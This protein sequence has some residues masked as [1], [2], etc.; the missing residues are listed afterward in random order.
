M[1]SVNETLKGRVDLELHGG[2]SA[3][4][5]GARIGQR[6]LAPTTAISHNRATGRPVTRSLIACSH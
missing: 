1:E 4:G 2:R 6:L 5:V 3:T